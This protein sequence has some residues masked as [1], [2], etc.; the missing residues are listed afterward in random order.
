M[1]IAVFGLGYVGIVNLACLSKLGHTVHGCDIKSHKVDA[2]LSKKSPVLEEGV[3]ELIK[4]GFERKLIHAST[5]ASVVAAN[6]DMALICVGTPS[7]ADGTVNLDYSIN[8][9][10]E[11]AKNI[12]KYKKKYTIVYRSTV[13]PGTIEKYFIPELKEQLGSMFDNVTVA[14]LPEFLREG[15]A[16]KDFF[17]CSRIVIGVS[18]SSVTDLEEVFGFSKEIPLVYTDIKTAE[19]IK[20]VDNAFHATKITFAN[21]VYHIGAAYGIDVQRANEIFLMDKHLNISGQY[22]R[23]GL[24]FGGSCLPKDMR[25][26]NHLATEKNINAPLMASI[27][28]SNN[29]MQKKLYE[30]II[31]FNKKA[32]LLVGLSFKNYTDDVRESSMLYLANSLISNGYDLKIYDPDINITTLRIENPW[33]VKYVTEDIESTIRSTEL[34]VVCKR[35]MDQVLK[36]ARRDENLIFN[37][38]NQDA[39]LTDVPMHY[40]YK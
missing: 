32:V 26:I 22:L 13:P 19:F 25:A 8:T 40:L 24:P 37:C 17:N 4:D 34:V 36:Y 30:K 9:T 33:I 27:L 18:G 1:K 35:F 14:F 29:E 2:V 10:I 20:Y 12:K 7:R 15:S 3:E 16:V 38:F 23:P 28:S 21:E 11:L 31:A 5:D 6:T 39:Y